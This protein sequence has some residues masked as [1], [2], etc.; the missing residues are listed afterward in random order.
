MKKSRKIA[1]WIF[2]VWMCLGMTSSAIVQLIGIKDEVTMF[3]HLGFPL[4][5]MKLIGIWKL[6]GV[7]AV[8]APRFPVLKE[9]AYA[10]FV[11]VMSGAAAA[12]L[13]MHDPFGETFP[14][15]FLLTLTLLSWYLRPSGRKM[16]MA[17]Q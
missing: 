8:L 16:V 14:S 2:T 15:I 3:T 13:I 12:H 4:Y 6:A 11:F 17:T 5:M 9:W 1:Y 7:V 10:G